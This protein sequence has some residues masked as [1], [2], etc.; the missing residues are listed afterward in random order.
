MVVQEPHPHLCSLPL[1]PGVPRASASLHQDHN[2]TRASVCLFVC[3]S[4]WVGADVSLWVCECEG[5]GCGGDTGVGGSYT[6][7]RS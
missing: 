1:S 6:V 4:G 5:M 7:H 2:E 3:L